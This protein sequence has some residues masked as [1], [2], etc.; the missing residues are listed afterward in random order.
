MSSRAKRAINR[1]ILK[2]PKKTNSRLLKE[3]NLDI[4]K[5]TLQK[6]LKEE[7]WTVNISSKKPILDVE[8]AKMRLVY[9]K[10]QLKNLSNINLRKI[11]FSDE[12]GI[13]RGHGACKGLRQ[14]HDLKVR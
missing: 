11:I 5:R 6:V 9:C 4:S 7:G 10:N 1:D 12:S 2:S 14:R 3:N 13:E 8:K